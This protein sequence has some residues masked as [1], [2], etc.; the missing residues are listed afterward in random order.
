MANLV[1]GKR[2]IVLGVTV[3]GHERE[4]TVVGDVELECM[5]VELVAEMTGGLLF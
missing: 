2:D 1:V 4:E 3:I 5:L